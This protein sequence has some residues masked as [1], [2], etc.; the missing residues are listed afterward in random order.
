M[1]RNSQTYNFIKF[2]SLRAEFLSKTRNH[3]SRK[4][5]RNTFYETEKN[6]AEFISNKKKSKNDFSFAEYENSD[7]QSEKS[8]K[9]LIIEEKTKVFKIKKIID[10]FEEKIDDNIIRKIKSKQFELEDPPTKKS[11]LDDESDKDSVSSF[12]KQEVHSLFAPK[13]EKEKIVNEIKDESESSQPKNNLFLF[14][15]H[16]ENTSKAPPTSF[17]FSPTTENSIPSLFKPIKTDNLFNNETSTMKNQTPLKEIDKKEIPLLSIPI[18]QTNLNNLPS[19]TNM[20][21]EKEKPLPLFSLTPKD[22]E[23][24]L[25]KL[26]PVQSKLNSETHKEDQQN[27]DNKI[28]DKNEITSLTPIKSM[29]KNPNVEKK[30]EDSS[31]S[32]KGE[33]TTPKTEE[34]IHFL[35]SLKNEDIKKENSDEPKVEDNPFLTKNFSNTP[36]LSDFLK[37][38]SKNLS[39]FPFGGSLIDNNNNNMNMTNQLQPNNVIN[40][41]MFI[42]SNSPKLSP[43]TPF[44]SK[45]PNNNSIHNTTNNNLISPFS[46]INGVQNKIDP[47]SPQA[48]NAQNLTSTPLFGNNTGSTLFGLGQVN[49]NN[50]NSNNGNGGNG[51]WG[52]GLFGN[53]LN[54]SNLANNN[55]LMSGINNAMS[56]VSN[57][58]QE[59]SL[60]ANLGGNNLGVLGNLTQNSGVGNSKYNKK[61]KQRI[62]E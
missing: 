27:E 35:S 54:N 51:N 19:E 18:K 4:R 3:N 47:T 60:F 36:N 50:I 45:S 16:E 52:G 41:D 23:G 40:N 14:N 15:K 37:S 10:A 24:S 30:I 5:K 53:L 56:L 34:K 17:L 6:L 29:E 7:T 49:N 38:E 2:W 22:S 39:V 62:N 58:S 48:T 46:F 21:K 55:N 57:P 32:Q 11:K 43:I 8:D 25:F 31:I 1:K 61:R 26:F 33:D 59:N 28:K 13:T 12:K 9:Q 42:E 20:N 44:D